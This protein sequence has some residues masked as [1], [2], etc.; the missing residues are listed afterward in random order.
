MRDIGQKGAKD[1]KKSAKED[2]WLKQ[3]EQQAMKDYRNKDLQD[4]SDL[5]AKIFNEKRGERDNESEKDVL[6]AK[7]RSNAEKAMTLD[8]N[9][10]LVSDKHFQ[11]SA[12]KRPGPPSFGV[13][14]KSISTEGGS[15]THPVSYTHLRAHET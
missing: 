7:N 13:P 2:Q 8:K 14:A 1:E 9:I 5:T 4:N 12:T 11:S 15:I 10:G 6:Q 3:M